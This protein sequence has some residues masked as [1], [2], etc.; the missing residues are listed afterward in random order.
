MPR[1]ISGRTDEVLRVLLDRYR[2]SVRESP[3]VLTLPESSVVESF[4][5]VARETCLPTP[6]SVVIPQRA[7]EEL[8]QCLHPFL[9]AVDDRDGCQIRSAPT[10]TTVVSVPSETTVVDTDLPESLGLTSP[11]SAHEQYA[12]LWE[13]AVEARFDTP[14]HERLLSETERRL[15]AQSRSVVETELDR[16]RARSGREVDVVCL[17]LWAGAVSN[18]SARAVIDLVE[19]LDIMSRGTVERRLERL[20][21]DEGLIDTLP[22]HDGTSGRPSRELRVGDDIDIADPVDPPDWVR[23]VLS[24]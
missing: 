16:S 24:T 14:P 5:G 18:T 23:S 13:S 9:A 15:G 6:L 17:A 11:G 10:S 12:A 4:L 3:V 1:Q 19:S 21:D 8:P 22:L 7:V 20:R 2:L